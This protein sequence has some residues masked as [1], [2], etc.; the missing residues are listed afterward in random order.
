DLL[1]LHQVTIDDPA[2]K[3]T[4]LFAAPPSFIVR[5]SGSIFLT[6]V[7]ADRDTYLPHA[8]MAR[9]H[10][11][12]YTRAIMP[13]PAEDLRGELAALGLQEL[14]QDNWLRTPRAQTAAEA[15]SQ[16]EARLREQGR[17]GSIPGLTIIDPSLRVTYYRGR[18]ITPK[19]HTGVF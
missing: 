12:G 11:D 5:P 7:V 8:L 18:W 9:I 3:G 17:S 6:G 16:L 19:R 10:C 1:E 2:A 14:S 15:R 4:W 13:E